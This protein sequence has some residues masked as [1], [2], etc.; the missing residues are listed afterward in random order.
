MSSST[1]LPPFTPSSTV[2]QSPELIQFG[3]DCVALVSPLVQSTFQSISAGFQKTIVLDALYKIVSFFTRVLSAIKPFS[4]F[5]GKSPHL[6]KL[7]DEFSQ[8][9][10]IFRLRDIC[11]DLVSDRDDYFRDLCSV[12]ASVLSNRRTKA[13]KEKELRAKL[14][15]V[16]SSTS[17]SLLLS[18]YSF[19]FRSLPRFVHITLMNLF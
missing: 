16:V 19:L 6:R 10:P 3:N 5:Q 12:L 9:E 4:Q 18:T 11:K 8:F 7:D 15:A 17:S 2:S 13:M 14:R 1:T